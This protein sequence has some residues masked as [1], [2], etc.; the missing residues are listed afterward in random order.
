MESRLKNTKLCLGLV[1]LTAMIST[2]LFCIAALATSIPIRPNPLIPT[3]TPTVSPLGLVQHPV[4]RPGTNGRITGARLTL[5]PR[6]GS[7]GGLRLDRQ[8][9]LSPCQPV[10]KPSLFPRSCQAHLDDG[11]FVPFHSCYRFAACFGAFAPQ[12]AGLLLAI[13]HGLLALPKRYRKRLAGLAVG[14]EENSRKARYVAHRGQDALASMAYALL[15]SVWRTFIGAHSGEHAVSPPFPASPSGLVLTHT[16]IVPSR[17]V[18]CIFLDS[19][20]ESFA[21]KGKTRDAISCTNWRTSEASPYCVYM[22]NEP[23]EDRDLYLSVSQAWAQASIEDR[24]ISIK[25]LTTRG[26]VATRDKDPGPP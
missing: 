15:H 7:A 14:E 25:C 22:G 16:S 17:E 8:S 21:C 6:P 26:A 1:S 5:V 18:W 4:F 3:R 9:P 12:P 20:K 11:N 10:H 23:S 19:S 13:A 2:S 24:R